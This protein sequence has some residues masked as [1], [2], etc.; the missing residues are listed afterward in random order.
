MA[1]ESWVPCIFW[2]STLIDKVAMPSKAGWHKP[3]ISVLEKPRREHL[4]KVQASLDYRM[5]LCLK[6][7][8][9]F[10]EYSLSSR[11]DGNSSEDMVHRQSGERE[12]TSLATRFSEE[13]GLSGPGPG[14][15]FWHFTGDFPEALL[16]QTSIK[17]RMSFLKLRRNSKSIGLLGK[18]WGLL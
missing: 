11:Y 8:R 6:K 9:C 3:M 18:S 5:R 7:Q 1:K 13:H 2:D 15:N 12:A 17:D 14:A 16:I 4:C 10:P